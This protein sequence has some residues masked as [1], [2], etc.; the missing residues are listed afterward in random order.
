MLDAQ[1]IVIGSVSEAGEAFLL[2]LRAVSVE[3]GT[4]LAAANTKIPREGVVTLASG[5]IETRSAPE[6]AFRSA[7]APGWGQ[8]YNRSPVKGIA[9]ATAT[10]G[11]AITTLGLGVGSAVLYSVYS[12]YCLDEATCE[13]APEKRPQ[14]AQSLREQTDALLTATLVA[15]VVTGVAWSAGAAD[16][17]V[18]GLSLYE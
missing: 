17:L 16:A 6:A 15:G 2:T 8:F 7:V 1:A 18:D 12:G 9:F 5:A 4:V 3:G 11:A 14:Q 10:Y 13:D